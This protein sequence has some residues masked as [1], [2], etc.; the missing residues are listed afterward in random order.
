MG[1]IDRPVLKGACVYEKEK[2]CMQ[3][4]IPNYYPQ[5]QCIAGDCRHNCCIG[6]E[7]DIDEA[8]AEYYKDVHGVLGERLHTQIEW[9]DVP[10]FRLT[11]EERCPF[12]NRDNLCDVILELGEEGLCNICHEHP[13]FHNE[14]PGRI[15]SGIGLCCEAAGRL[16]LG[17]KEPVTLLVSG[18]NVCEDA[19]VALRDELLTILQDRS[20]DLDVRL[21]HMVGR[22][23]VAVPDQNWERWASFLLG[24]ERLDE[25]WTKRLCELKKEWAT[26][27]MEA[28]GKYMKPRETEYEQFA[29]SL[30]YR[31]FANGADEDDLGA[32]ASFVAFG[33]GLIRRL[34]A[35]A[36]TKTG[37]F[38]FEDQ[39]ELARLFSSELEYSEEN[40]DAVFDE[41]FEGCH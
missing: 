14:L 36:W 17:Q 24:L 5:F 22:C 18:E 35:I 7:I 13:R 16:I 6:W 8:T 28:F 10:H 30:L 26:V 25:A 4:V 20:L 12:L 29:V 27:D 38:S 34:G 3:Q 39:V 40:L 2:S 11:K 32:R 1:G 21:Q 19:F 31:H 33:C 9:G 37:H 41:L 23:C 15:E